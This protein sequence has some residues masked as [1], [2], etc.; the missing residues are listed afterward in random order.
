[1]CLRQSF[2]VITP[3][4]R[5]K[6]NNCL[7]KI[8]ANILQLNIPIV[9]DKG[10]AETE[11]SEHVNNRLHWGLVCHSDGRHVKNFLEA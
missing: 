4:K 3:S 9:S 8:P 2:F 5:L 11:F 10:L 6:I 1:M 7:E